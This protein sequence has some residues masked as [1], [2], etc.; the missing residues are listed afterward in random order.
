M[1][2][3]KEREE[4]VREDIFNI[5]NAHGTFEFSYDFKALEGLHQRIM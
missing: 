5:I 2:A 4:A 3:A 1:K